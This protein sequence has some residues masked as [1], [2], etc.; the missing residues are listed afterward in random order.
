VSADRIETDLLATAAQAEEER[1]ATKVSQAAPCGQVYYSAKT[2][3]TQAPTEAC[4]G[5]RVSCAHWVSQIIIY[6]AKPFEE[7]RCRRRLDGHWQIGKQ[8]YPSLGVGLTDYA[9]SRQSDTGISQT[10]EPI[11]Q[12]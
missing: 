4:Q 1:V 10:T 12:Y 5:E 3:P 2:S 11:N 9:E 7:S 8:R 6:Q